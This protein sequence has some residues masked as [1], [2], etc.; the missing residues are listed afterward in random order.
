[1]IEA[2]EP[3]E[4]VGPATDVAE[5][6]CRLT[7][8]TPQRLDLDVQLQQPGLVVL[9]DLFYPGWVAMR[10]DEQGNEIERL[11]VLRTNRVMRGVRL[12]AGS[13]RLSF[14]YRPLDFYVGAAIS[15]VAWLG[16]AIAVVLSRRRRMR[17]SSH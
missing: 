16:V 2:D 6:S 1:V 13:H 3:V 15:V 4:P 11:P 17:Q 9:N 7:S 14:R 8:V 5:E 12:P 10:V